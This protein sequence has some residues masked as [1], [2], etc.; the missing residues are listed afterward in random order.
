MALV[1]TENG[2]CEHTGSTCVGPV[3]GTLVG[4]QSFVTIEGSLV[5]VEAGTMEVPVHGNPPCFPVPILASHSYNPDTLQQNYF[6]IEGSLVVL[7]GD[8][9]NGDATEVDDAGQSFVSVN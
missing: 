6:Y 9:Y 1:A 7:Q 2:T 5:M 4:G 3:A 8:T